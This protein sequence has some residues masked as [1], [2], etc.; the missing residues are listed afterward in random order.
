MKEEE[1][2]LLLQTG[3]LLPGSD[4]LPDKFQSQKQ[5]Y[6]NSTTIFKEWTVK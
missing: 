4:P 3:S 2:Y 5:V 1:G 6:I